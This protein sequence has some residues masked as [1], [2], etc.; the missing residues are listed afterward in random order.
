MPAD[1]KSNH[2]AVLVEWQPAL[3]LARTCSGAMLR[4]FF[5]VNGAVTVTNSQQAFTQRLADMFA[6][7]VDR[8]R[9]FW[10]VCMCMCVLTGL[11]V[12]YGL[13]FAH[14]DYIATAAQSVDAAA[15]ADVVGHTRC[16]VVP[17]PILRV[18]A[19]GE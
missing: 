14:V 11:C 17:L 4:N 18:L 1:F 15:T 12:A 19:L 2:N 9:C 8:R 6:R 10:S 3:R 5:R 16:L 13:Q 7:Q